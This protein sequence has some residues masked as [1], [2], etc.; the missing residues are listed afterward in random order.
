MGNHKSA[1]PR[2][3]H[4]PLLL[5]TAPLLALLLATAAPLCALDAHLEDLRVRSIEF[6]GPPRLSGQE[7][8]LSFESERPSAFVGAR[9]AHEDFQ[10]LHPYVRVASAPP[11]SGG[12]PQRSKG[13]SFDKA[14]AAGPPPRPLFIL[15]LSV[16]PE[17]DTLRYRI[18][19]DGQWMADPYN[20]DY[21]Q[22]SFG[23]RISV[24][25]ITDRPPPAMFNPTVLSDGTVR[26]S[27]RDRPGRYVYIA[28]DFNHWN[29]YWDRLQELAPGEYSITLRLPAGRHYYR[30]AVDGEWR[31]DPHNPET[32]RDSE[33]V[34]VS[35]FQLSPPAAR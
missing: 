31:P 15:L 21:E 16:P 8:L 3:P 17:V 5:A 19:V 20:P 10:V 22:D 33:G 2:P 25:R 4:S 11:R 32:G 12:A 7:V 26:F 13:S 28:G 35:T 14:P 18:V 30:F 34:R 1:R 9:F 6:A 23:Q 24:F 29:P 27:L